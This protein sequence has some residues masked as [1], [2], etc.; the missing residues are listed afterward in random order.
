M[1]ELKTEKAFRI[2]FTRYDLGPGLGSSGLAEGDARIKSVH[3]IGELTL[4]MRIQ[5]STS[6]DPLD[7]CRRERE[8][9]LSVLDVLKRLVKAEQERAAGVADAW[10]GNNNDALVGKLIAAKIRSTR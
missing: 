3:E 6:A 7:A 1:S 5:M 9:Q 8:W 4:A 10:G 2:P